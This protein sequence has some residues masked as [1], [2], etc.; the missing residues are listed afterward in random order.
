MK[1][2]MQTSLS[3]TDFNYLDINP[4]RLLNYIVILYAN[5]ELSEKENNKAIPFT[6]ASKN[7]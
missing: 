6:I 2:G 7:I 1:L 5:N 3:D 4:V